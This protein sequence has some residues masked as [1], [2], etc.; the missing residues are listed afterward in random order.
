MLKSIEGRSG[1]K[2]PEIEAYY[3]NN[4]RGFISDVVNEE[5]NK[6]SFLLDNLSANRTYNTVLTRNPQTGEYTLSYER[7]EIQ[8]SYK[9]LTAQT[10][11][12]LLVAMRNSRTNNQPDFVQSDIDTVRAQNALIPAV[13]YADWKRKGVAGGVDALAIITETL[14]NFY[15]DPN[16]QTYEAVRGIYARY[17]AVVGDE[18]ATIARVSYVHVLG[19]L[20]SGLSK[21][22]LDE[23]DLIAAARIPNDPRFNI[24][25]TRYN[26]V[27]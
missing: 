3:R 22:V 12:A 7:P 6:I 18:F 24:F 14:T 26:S 15:L 19:Q 13:V 23:R 9:T 20:N 11:D 8:N 16:R 21:M 17:C 5:F 27:K 25:L 4:I 10:L 2:R 1:V